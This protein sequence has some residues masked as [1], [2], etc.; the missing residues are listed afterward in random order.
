MGLPVYE[1][2]T[3]P[4]AEMSKVTLN[5][6][7]KENPEVVVQVS[8]DRNKSV[9]MLKK[10]I[11]EEFQVA[12]KDIDAAGIKIWFAQIADDDE[13][14]RQLSDDDTSV[15]SV[16]GTSE[17]HEASQVMWKVEYFLSRFNMND[18][19]IHVIVQGREKW[20]SVCDRKY[21]TNKLLKDHV[22]H[23]GIH[24]MLSGYKMR[25][26]DVEEEN[27]ADPEPNYSNATSRD[28]IVMD[29]AGYNNIFG[30]DQ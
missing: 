11:K 9:Y 23:D 3:A 18:D 1:E 20:C 5:C 28:H 4:S 24:Y 14:L 27:D 26:T 25:S 17:T 29:G 8:I 12:F 7:V 16:F 15:E 30:K 2:I 6:I 10:A 19:A 22:L 13:R 21:E